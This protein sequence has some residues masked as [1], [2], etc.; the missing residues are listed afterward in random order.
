MTDFVFLKIP[1]KQLLFQ[2][3]MGFEAASI[4]TMMTS[5]ILHWS[6]EGPNNPFDLQALNFT[7]SSLSIGPRT[8]LV[9]SSE[10]RFEQCQQL[11]KSHSCFC[12][13]LRWPVWAKD[14]V[15]LM[16]SRW[17]LHQNTTTLNGYLI[18]LLQ[19][20]PALSITYLRTSC[21]WWQT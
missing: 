16:H 14:S 9:C 4:A 7:D 10:S 5:L 6:L 18:I 20:S 13:W 19:M 2:Q 12:H 17:Y 21:F 3:K 11:S 15:W 8:P 1:S